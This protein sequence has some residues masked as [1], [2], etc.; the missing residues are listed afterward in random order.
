MRAALL[1]DWGSCI[2]T[3]LLRILTLESKVNRPARLINQW[4]YRF[5]HAR[6]LKRDTD[7]GQV[8]L[9]LLSTYEAVQVAFDD[10]SE[11]LGDAAEDE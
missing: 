3:R 1:T 2:W 4:W 8:T 11:Y 7:A 10:V 9:Q 6:L 5:Q